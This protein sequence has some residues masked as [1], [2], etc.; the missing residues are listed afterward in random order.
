MGVGVRVGVEVYKMK[1]LT[2]PFRYQIE[3]CNRLEDFNGRGLIADEPGLGKSLQAL[4]YAYNNPQLRPVVVVCPASLKWNWA[5]ELERHFGTTAVVLGGTKRPAKRHWRKHQFAIVNYDILGETRRQKGGKG[6]GEYLTWLQ[7]KLIV[8]DESHYLANRTSLRTRWVRQLCVGVNHVIALSG[9]PIVNLPKELWPTLNILRPDL[10]PNFFPFGHRY[11]GAV[12][13]FWGWTF[14]G[15]TNTQELNKQLLHHCMIRRTQKEVL[16][17][18]P[19]M[20]RGVVPLEITHPEQYQEAVDDFATWLDKHLPDRK[21]RALKAEAVTQL[22]YLKRLAAKLKMPAV[23]DH[24]G[25]YYEGSDHKFLVFAV[26]KEIVAQLADRFRNH[27]VILTGD[28]PAKHRKAVV[29]EFQTNPKKRVF[30]GNIK[31]AGVGLNLTAARSV[32]FAEMDWVPGNHTQA[33]KR[34]HRIG[35]EFSINAY[36]LVARGTIEENLCRIIQA[37]QKTIR[38]A[39]D[40]TKGGEKLDVY[41]QLLAELYSRRDEKLCRSKNHR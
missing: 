22:G 41:D 1:L 21:A 20:V 38:E 39:I 27:C 9:T 16:K 26:H 13:N 17:D 2:K 15:A 4:L 24:L 40:G 34:A 30:I 32:W 19:K 11:C 37:K 3:G 29:K 18:L 8:L 7:P 25:N 31:A 6:W 35:T 12:K 5:Q 33:E 28:T 14:D 23:L 36:Y 10:Y